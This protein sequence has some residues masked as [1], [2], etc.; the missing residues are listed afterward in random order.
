LDAVSNALKAYTGENY[1]LQA[2]S[3]HSMQEQ[4][5]KSIAAAY[6]GI[7]SE[8]GKMYWGAGTHTD[9]IKA[10][11]NALLSAFNNMVRG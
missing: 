8:R 4:G 1:T 2:Y 5:S 6:I 10:S 3:E 11:T 7:Q 9:V